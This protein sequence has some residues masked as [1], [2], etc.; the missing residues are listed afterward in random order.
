MNCK[1][2]DVAVDILVRVLTDEDTQY[3]DVE[4]E[5][6]ELE[7]L[8]SSVVE[9]QEE[10]NALYATIYGAK[11]SLSDCVDELEGFILK[12]TY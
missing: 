2:F 1:I 5:M 9:L 3:M 7:R 8:C 12:L 11:G 6:D 4:K 10:W